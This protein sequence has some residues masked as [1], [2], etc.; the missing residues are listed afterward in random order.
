[1][2]SLTTETTSIDSSGIPA[3]QFDI[4]A[5]WKLEPRRQVKNEARKCPTAGS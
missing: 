1:M 4:P 5:D 2:V 3:D